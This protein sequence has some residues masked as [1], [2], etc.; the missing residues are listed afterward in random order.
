MRRLARSYFR[1]RRR[2]LLSGLA[3]CAILAIVAVELPGVVGAGAPTPA[4]TAA[5]AIAGFDLG[6]GPIPSDAP[7]AKFSADD[8]KQRALDLVGTGGIEVSQQHEVVDAGPGRG[9]RTAWVL[10][11]SG[12]NSMDV[13]WG[14]PGAGT[15]TV[16]Y[17]GVVVDD[18]SG[19][20]LEWLHAGHH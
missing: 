15:P 11:F 4:Q 2:L 9:L 14:P 7:A 5:K 10:F 20:I 16:D 12:G 18:Q 8:A 19:E 6:V 17:T 1:P 3:A 13:S